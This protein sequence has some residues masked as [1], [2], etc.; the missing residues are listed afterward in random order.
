MR[1]RNLAIGLLA[2]AAVLAGLSVWG[3]RR[4]DDR[5]F[6]AELDRAGRELESGLLGTAQKRRGTMIGASR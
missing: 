2:M 5:R 1:R 3:W 6:R 4:A